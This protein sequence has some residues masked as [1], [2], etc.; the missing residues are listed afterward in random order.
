MGAVSASEGCQAFHT[1]HTGFVALVDSL[2][3]TGDAHLCPKRALARLH[4]WQ[5]F[6]SAGYTPSL[7]GVYI[8]AVELQDHTLTLPVPG[9]PLAVPSWVLS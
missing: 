1:D 3:P 2:I 7:S 6:A 4:T 8:T 5:L 9:L